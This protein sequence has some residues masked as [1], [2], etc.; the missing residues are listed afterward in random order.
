VKDFVSFF[1]KHIA[2]TPLRTSQRFPSS[3]NTVCVATT[4]S[5][6]QWLYPFVSQVALPVVADLLGHADMLGCAGS[7]SSDQSDEDQHPD[8][9]L[10]HK[11]SCLSVEEYPNVGSWIDNTTA[12]F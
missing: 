5:S 3:K 10:F 8:D 12:I 4:P 9:C 2:G 1:T 7:C 11:E 6:G